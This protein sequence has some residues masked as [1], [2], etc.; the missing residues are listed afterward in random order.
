MSIPPRYAKGPKR[1]RWTAYEVATRGTSNSNDRGSSYSR[2]RRRDWVMKVFESDVPNHVRCYRCGD[3]LNDDTLTIDRVKPG[4]RGG[5]Y[6]PDNIR[7]ACGKCNSSEGA[8]LA[9]AA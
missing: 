3:L 6:Y 7:P 1:G 9:H 5:K 8:K 2:R 4:C